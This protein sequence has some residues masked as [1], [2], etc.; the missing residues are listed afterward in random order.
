MLLL[1]LA[2]KTLRNI[3]LHLLN[4]ISFHETEPSRLSYRKTKFF[5]EESD[6]SLKSA[7]GKTNF[8]FNL[9]NIKLNLDVPLYQPRANAFQN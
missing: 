8:K 1:P 6:G 5:T 4:P 7:A 3:I 9:E 2:P